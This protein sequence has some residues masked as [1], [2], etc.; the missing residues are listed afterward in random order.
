MTA[1]E[2]LHKFYP[3]SPKA[4]TFVPYGGKSKEEW[5][6]DFVAQFGAIKPTSAEQYDKERQKKTPSWQ[7]IARYIDVTRWTELLL[8]L[9]LEKGSE[10]AILNVT[11]TIRIGDMYISD[12]EWFAGTPSRET[13]AA[14]IAN[15]VNYEM[16]SLDGHKQIIK[17]A[18]GV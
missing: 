3:P 2:F 9:G 11:H 14:A 18:A 7:T 13:M 16:K 15:G 17:R 5:T 1:K 6:K 10:P 8:A 4:H 12:E